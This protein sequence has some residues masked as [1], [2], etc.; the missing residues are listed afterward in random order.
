[1]NDAR[2]T[3][4]PALRFRGDGTFTILQL[5]D[6][7]WRNGEARDRLTRDLMSRM[8]EREQP[9]LTLFTGDLIHGLKCRD[10]VKSLCDSLSVAAASGAPWAAVFGNH[11]A[12]GSA[13]RRELMDAMRG[14]TGCL[15]QA[16][17]ESV[18]GLSN[19]AIRLAGPG[20]SCC[21]VL[22]MLDSGVLPVGDDGIH[23]SQLEWLEREA[24]AL[25]LQHDGVFV[26]ALAFFHVPLP[27]YDRMW[28][29]QVCDGRKRERVS[30]PK[31]NVGAWRAMVERTG[32]VG[33]FCGHDHLNDYGGQLQRTRLYYGRVSGYHAYARWLYPRGARVIRL[34]AGADLRDFETWIRLHDGRKL[35]HPRLHRPRG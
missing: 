1:M 28:R 31:V 3:E 27:E 12:E 4:W 7:H 18:H 5:T 8:F 6:L 15:A 25:A 14:M 9:D 21:A 17:P 11:D 13:T 20:G 32:V 29:T 26:P 35:D 24:A 16:G 10:P 22:Y 19:C 30:C 34:R 33:T 23:P 2:S